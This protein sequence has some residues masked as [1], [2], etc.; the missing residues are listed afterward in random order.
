[1]KKQKTINNRSI[2]MPLKNN[3]K[4]KIAP[5]VRATSSEEEIESIVNEHGIPGTG[6][7]VSTP[8]E[9]SKWLKNLCR[10]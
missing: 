5:G 6:Y 4:I 8:Q 2:D 10:R 9:L 3:P 1:M 7:T